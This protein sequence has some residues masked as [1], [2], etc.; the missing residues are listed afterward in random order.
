MLGQEELTTSFRRAI[1]K[2]QHNRSC[3]GE[4]RKTYYVVL[5]LVGRPSNNSMTAERGE[6]RCRGDQQACQYTA[7][8]G[9]IT[10]DV[11]SV[12]RDAVRTTVQDARSSPS[13]AV[14]QIGA[15]TW[16][17]RLGLRLVNC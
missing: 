8:K 2:T 10:S 1:L 17:R 15:C 6:I 13:T 3:F 9:H 11:L 5:K 4:H 16:Q 12:A 7:F 14:A